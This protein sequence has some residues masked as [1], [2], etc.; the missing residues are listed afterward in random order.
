M[1]IDKGT[2]TLNKVKDRLKKMTP[3]EF[4]EIHDKAT[5]QKWGKALD[6]LTEV[7]EELDLY[8]AHTPEPIVTDSYPVYQDPRLTRS[9]ENRPP[10]TPPRNPNNTDTNV[11]VENNTTIENTQ[12][13][14]STN[15]NTNEFNP[16]IN[17]E[18]NFDFSGLGELFE[19]LYP[20]NRG[21]DTINIY[22]NHSS[23]FNYGFRP[24]NPLPLFQ[25]QLFGYQQSQLWGTQGVNSP[26]GFYVPRFI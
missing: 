19:R 3:E 13:T 8:E 5:K 9:P 23:Q 20:E 2:E 22:N 15:T 12:K 7:S 18:L 6:Q 24:W 1:K 16:N 11:E 26:L 10:Q 4:K 21:G 14:T 25:Q 17:I